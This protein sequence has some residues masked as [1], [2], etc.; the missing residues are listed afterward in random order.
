MMGLQTEFHI[1]SRWD[2]CPNLFSSN[3]PYAFTFALRHPLP[4]HGLQYRVALC[5]ITIEHKW[6]DEGLREALICMDTVQ[7]SYVYGSDIKLIRSVLLPGTREKKTDRFA[8]TP[9]YFP[10]MFGSQNTQISIR[11]SRLEPIT[12]EIESVSLHLHYTL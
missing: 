2:D 3:T 6:P 9:L 10:V 12:T 7:H 11:D 1:V 8:F 4:T 5:E